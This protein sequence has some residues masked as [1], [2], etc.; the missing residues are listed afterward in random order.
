VIDAAEVEFDRLRLAVNRG[1]EVWR[2]GQ[3]AAATSAVALEKLTHVAAFRA[4][5]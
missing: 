5:K 1:A 4:D 2:F 3:F